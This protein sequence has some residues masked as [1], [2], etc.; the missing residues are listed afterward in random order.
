MA[1]YNEQPRISPVL[2][3]LSRAELVDEI[4]VVDDGSKDG[5]G[6]FVRNTFPN[7]K[8][9]I[10][11]VNQGKA[12]SM[13]RGVKES[14]ND[15]IF[16]CDADLAG[17]DEKSINEIIKPV[18]DNEYDMFIGIR[19]NIM[20]KSFLPFALNSGERSMR[21]SV[22]MELPDFYK[23]RF[24]IE[25]G[26]NMKVYFTGEKG[27]GYKVMPYRQTLKEKKWGFLKGQKQRLGMNIDVS[28]GWI[29]SFWD[30]FLMGYLIPRIFKHSKN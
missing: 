20:Q 29:R 23:H 6:Q 21:K 22:W 26:L 14:K 1:A 7:I 15:V 19:D 5:T 28:I 12:Y 27:M 13:D 17:L 24:R 2:Q 18:L 4:I 8:T 30:F 10:N 16:F 11:A 25:A 9:F 3:A